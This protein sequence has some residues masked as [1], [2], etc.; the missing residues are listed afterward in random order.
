MG[1]TA[2]T[3]AQK[4]L[5]ALQEKRERENAAADAYKDALKR[6]LQKTGPK[7]SFR[8]FATRYSINYQLLQR[9]V[10]N[11]GKSK[12]DSNAAKGR[13]TMIE[14]H[15]LIDF[16]IEMAHRGFPLTPKSLTRYAEE[17]VHTRDPTAKFGK[18][19]ATRF[20]VR[21]GN[22]ISTKWSVSL[23]TVR[24]RSV[25]INTVNHWY[26]LLGA[27]LKLHNFRRELIFGMDETGC[28]LGGGQ[29]TRVIAPT[30]EKIQHAQRDGSK[31]NVTVICCICADGSNVPPV[32]IFKGKNML[33]KWKQDNPI[34]AA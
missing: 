10:N 30:D 19:W 34:D 31:E 6:Y 5:K 20:L 27:Q 23:D 12:A 21:H 13:L 11:V 15:V 7:P 3:D 18:N 16:S 28:P 24:A 4:H 32:I 25:N 29:K 8:S 1:R 2:Q 22:Q 26:N 33:A 9:R 17:I 14:T